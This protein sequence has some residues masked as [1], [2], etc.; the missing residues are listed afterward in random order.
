MTKLHANGAMGTIASR[1][2]LVAVRNVSIAIAILTLEV[3]VRP[4]MTVIHSRISCQ[5]PSCTIRRG[6]AYQVRIDLSNVASVIQIES[7]GAYLINAT[8][9]TQTPS[10]RRQAHQRVT[11]LFVCRAGAMDAT[12]A[13]RLKVGSLHG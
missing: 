3:S 8:S 11:I 13:T 5:V 4:V 2:S 1:R 10:P 7:M 6:S 9:A 12:I